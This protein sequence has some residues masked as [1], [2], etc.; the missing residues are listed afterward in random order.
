[1]WLL[2]L[3]RRTAV[4]RLRRL[5][6]TSCVWIVFFEHK[7]TLLLLPGA[8]LQL[9]VLVCDVCSDSPFLGLMS[10]SS[11]SRHGRG[12]ERATNRPLWTFHVDIRMCCF[13]F[14]CIVAKVR[15]AMRAQR[16]CPR[17]LLPPSVLAKLRCGVCRFA[18]FFCSVHCSRSLFEGTTSFR[19]HG[20]EAAILLRQ[21]VPPCFHLDCLTRVQL[22]RFS[23]KTLQSNPW[24]CANAVDCGF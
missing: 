8:F 20:F 17:T 15:Y 22:T 5:Q 9:F 11:S 12:N 14:S 3:G 18:L 7:P 21:H 2:R 10:R 24:R 6:N 4:F 23:N 13:W 19:Q 16:Q 1:M